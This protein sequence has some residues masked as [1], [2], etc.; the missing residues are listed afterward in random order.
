MLGDVPLG[1][2]L[3]GGID[4]STVVAM[5]QAASATRVR[6][7]TIGFHEHGFDEAAHARAVAKHLGT[8]HTELYVTPQDALAVVPTLAR[9]Y[10]EPFSDSSQIPTLLLS[11]LTRRHVTVSLSGDGADELFGGYSRYQR[12]ASAWASMARL[13]HTLRRAGSAVIRSVPAGAWDALSLPARP[14]L[15]GSA[16]NVGHRA[17]KFASLAEQGHGAAFYQRFNC[18]WPFPE[19][20]VVGGR[21]PPVAQVERAGT[22]HDQMM[23]ADARSYLPDDILVKV[24]RAAMACSL[25]TR[26]PFLDPDVIALAASLPLSMKLRGG[27]GKWILRQVL[28][29]YVP[30]SLVDR[31]KA[32]FAVPVGSWL[33]GPLRPWAEELLGAQRLAQEGFFRPAPLRRMWAE[34]LSGRRDWHYQLWDVL[35]F[36]QW[37][38]EQRQP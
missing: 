36:Q 28:D 20:V 12:V 7:F 15:R 26:V 2:F 30:R 18:H 22:L 35:M 21:L 32:G 16:A 13:P 38:Q 37:W 1:A 10:D 3:S 19:Q 9:T 23:G 17:H 4:S 14:W 5:M 27:Q 29:R 25:E 24:D 31:P 34:H 33:R 6:T 8:E 11:Q